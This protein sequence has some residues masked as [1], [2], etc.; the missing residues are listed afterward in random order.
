MVTTLVT[1]AYLGIA[2]FAAGMTYDEQCQKGQLSP[3]F[4]A[5]GFL[6][7][8]LWPVTLLA[9]LVAVR[10]SAFDGPARQGSAL[11]DV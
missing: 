6:A 5:L 3:L 1:I 11:K 9:V 8:A 10:I 4:K 2:L 7:C